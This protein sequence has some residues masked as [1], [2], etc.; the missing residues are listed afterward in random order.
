MLQNNSDSI[1]AFVDDLVKSRNLDSLDPEVAAQLKT[2][3]LDRVEDRINA[4]ILANIPPEKLEHFEKLLD[5]SSSEEVQSFCR[6]NIYGLPEII[7]KELAEF[8]ETYL[9]A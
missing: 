2:D 1:N 3:L 7:A 9:S 5:Q 4:V 8:R 6:R